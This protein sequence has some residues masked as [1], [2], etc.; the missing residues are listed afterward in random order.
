MQPAGS[1]RDAIMR[2]SFLVAFA[3]DG[4]IDGDEL[5]FIKRLALRDGVVDDGERDVL[6]RIFARVSQ[7][8][9]AP[10]VWQELQ[11]FKQEHGIP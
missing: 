10:E 4:T 6:S 9:V 8:G 7:A 1:E 11:A 3:N 2:Y 5:A